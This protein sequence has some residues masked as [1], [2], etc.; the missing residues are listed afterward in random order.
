MIKFKVV[1]YNQS[2]D[3][4]SNTTLI[5]SINLGKI[6][7]PYVG[8]VNSV[9]DDKCEGYIEIKH[10]IE[11]S[12]YY[13]TFCNV[14]KKVV[15]R[16]D[17]VRTGDLIGYT[18]EKET[19]VIYTLIKD[20]NKVNPSNFFRNDKFIGK[21][22][23]K[24]KSDDKDVKSKKT[25]KKGDTKTNNVKDT[26][27]KKGTSG[28]GDSGNF[29][30]TLMLSPLNLVGNKLEKGSDSVKDEFK[31]IT[32]LKSKKKKEEESLNEELK[33]IKRLL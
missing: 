7:S 1:G 11:D 21:K 30:T 31:N 6:Y 13:S 23:D 20:R 29:L 2:Y 9:Y 15:G 32:T 18:K 22:D 27:S 24:D 17:K 16:G 28:K 3:S 10:E 8:V 12:I 4:R 25:D 14:D 5:K 26:T 19:D 33:R